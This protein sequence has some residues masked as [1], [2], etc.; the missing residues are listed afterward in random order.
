MTPIDELLAIMARLRDPQLGCPWDREQTFATIVPYT[1]EEA[2]EVADAIE[3]GDM[4]ELKAELGDLL[5]QVVFY[6]QM[7]NEAGS[8][9][10]NAVVAGIIEKMLRR[11]PHVFADAKVGSVSEQAQA[12]EQHK[13]Q[14]RAEKNQQVAP[15]LLDDIPRALPAMT[16]AMKL[17]KR[18]SRIG[19]D[20]K[21]A[22][23][24]LQKLDEEVEE[25]RVEIESAAPQERITDEIGDL[26][27]V[28]TI[29]ARHSGVDP[30]SALR[31]A[32]AKFERRFGR[33][34]ALAKAQGRDIKD[35]NL[36]QQDALWDQVKAEEQKPVKTGI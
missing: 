11:H 13:A 9:D 27:F 35:L 14:E 18:A 2:Y 29:L 30:E 26:L 3:R 24:V 10:F 20:W 22:A 6:A 21:H 8:F 16:R 7:A 36:Q 23:D 31:H 32:N 33:M 12:W 19:F 4:S 25:L 1:I 17:H 28:T 34:E 5:F 15:G